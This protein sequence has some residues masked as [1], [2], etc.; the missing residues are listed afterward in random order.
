MALPC[1]RGSPLYTERRD[2]HSFLMPLALLMMVG[3]G[4]LGLKLL[5]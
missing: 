4:F 3:V 5:P 1:L 2:L